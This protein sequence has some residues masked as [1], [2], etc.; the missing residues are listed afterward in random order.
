M[1]LERKRGVGY[2]RQECI[3]CITRNHFPSSENT[4]AYS[5]QS[6]KDNYFNSRSKLVN[7]VDLFG[8]KVCK[9]G[10]SSF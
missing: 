4:N 9:L 8:Y 10:L 5:L 3:V 7:F 1:T 2:S 6:P